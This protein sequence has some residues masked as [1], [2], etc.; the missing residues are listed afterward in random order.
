MI[1]KR[2]ALSAIGFLTDA[3]DLF[4]I[5]LVAIIMAKIYPQSSF[6]V[7]L[8]T[9]VALFAAMIGQIISGILA[10]YFGRRK[11][12]VLTALSIMFGCFASAF[13]TIDHPSFSIYSQ[14]AIWRFITGMAIGAE[15]PLSAVISSE[16]A[17]SVQSTTIVFCMQGFGS[18]GSCLLITL[19]LWMEMDLEV[20]WRLALTFGGLPGLLVFYPRWKLHESHEFEAL[21]NSKL[22]LTPNNEDNELLETHFQMQMRDYKT[23]NHGKCNF[24]WLVGCAATWFLFDIAFYANSLFSA[25]ILKAMGLGVNSLLDQALNTTY[26]SLIAIPGYLLAI[27]AIPYFGLKNIQLLGFLICAILY[28]LL[29]VALEPLKHLPVLLLILY[30]LTFVFSNLGPN[31]TTFISPVVIF[32]T[33]IRATS[34]GVSAAMGKLGAVLGTSLLKPLY[35]A[36][37]LPT[38]LLICALISVMGFLMTIF[39]IPKVKNFQTNTAR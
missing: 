4:V 31:S 9:T 27:I 10:D 2:T 28:I 1:S 18:L 22:L 21:T 16:N 24:W 13:F 30:G 37:G 14:L 6:D 32:P 12:F 7:S 8:V 26:L 17:A 11:L 15:Y 3:Y 25:T 35:N 19:C 20:I 39:F 33:R 36:Y 34:H 5:N 29:S 38:V 23:L